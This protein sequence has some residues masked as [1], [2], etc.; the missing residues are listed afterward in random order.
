MHWFWRAAIGIVA[1][2]IYCGLGVTAFDG[3]NEHVADIIESVLPGAARRGG[4]QTGI[5]CAVV[6]F[7]PAAIIAVAIYGGLTHRFARRSDGEVRCRK[8]GYIL[9]GISEPRCPECG[10]RI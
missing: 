8:C 7:L 6:Y 2:C 4:W 10:E 3:F 5:S 9:R 1:A